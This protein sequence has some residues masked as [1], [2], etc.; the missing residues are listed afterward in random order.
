MEVTLQSVPNL[1]PRY[2]VVGIGLLLF[3]VVIPIPWW[4]KALFCI[5]P[6]VLMGTYR[7]A[8]IDGDKFRSQLVVGFVPLKPIK[9]NLPAVLYIE[10]KYN[11][12]GEGAETFMALKPIKAVFST[13]MDLM[14]PLMGGA[15]EIWLVT[16]KGREI[17]AWQG[18][19]QKLFEE[20]VA[21]LTARTGAELRGRSK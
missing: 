13:I 5:V 21:L 9:C 20:N 17:V 19:N 2:W 16:A 4:T 12:V 7:T 6:L 15:Y 10:T 11:D 1:T 18:F 8:T 14:I 3:M